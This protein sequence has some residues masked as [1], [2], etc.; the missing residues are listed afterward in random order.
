[1]HGLRSLFSPT[2]NFI[3]AGVAFQTRSKEFKGKGTKQS[4]LRQG[5]IDG[6]SSRRIEKSWKKEVWE[7]YTCTWE[8]KGNEILLYITRYVEGQVYA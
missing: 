5:I 6:A 4:Q 7:D 3:R 1:M 2:Q 8:N